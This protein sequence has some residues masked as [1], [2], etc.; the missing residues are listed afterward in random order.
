VELAPGL[1]HRLVGEEAQ[2]VTTFRELSFAAA[3]ALL[4]VFM[5]LAGT[6]ESLVHPLT[7]VSAVPLAL[8]GVA[9]LLVP[10]GRPIGVMEVLGMIVLSGVAVNDAI[11]LVST[12]V[13]LMRKGHPRREALARAAGIRLR[14]ILMTTATTVLAL[15]PLAVG[16]GE[17]ARLRSPLAITVIGGIVTSTLGSLLLIP[18]LYLL[19]DRLRLRRGARG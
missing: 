14:P 10:L 1:R 17:A 4:L 18:S 12:A 7:V 15:M 8:I 6:F 19:L 2:R 9:A 13:Q 11:L 3:L 5:V 16:A